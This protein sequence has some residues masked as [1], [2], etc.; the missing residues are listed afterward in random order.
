M[1]GFLDALGD[2]ARDALRRLGTRRTFKRGAALFHERQDGD[3]VFLIHAG[4]VKLARVTEEGKDVVLGVRGPGELLGEL[5]I[6]DG[7][8]RSSGAFAVTAV[9]A[10]VIP[11]SD[12]LSF[13]SSTSEAA[14]AL[15]QMLATR[16]R[17]SDE[18]IF[19]FVAHD[20]VG[21]LAGRLVELAR[22]HGVEE[23]GEI[24]IDLPLS[25]EELAG[26]VGASRESVARALQVLRD[27]GWVE[28]GRRRVVVRDLEALV[29][30]A[31]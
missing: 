23:D 15:L 20:T 26:W 8:S 1:R 3:R 31:S 27:L 6:I 29:Q 2:D 9:E 28:T 5:S 10:Q 16:L 7:G 19:Q 17:A 22:T 18:T 14:S 13:V 11:A 30:R 25:Q 12:F 24:R 4:E 21:R